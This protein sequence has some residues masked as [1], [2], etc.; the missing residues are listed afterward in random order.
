MPQSPASYLIHTPRYDRTPVTFILQH[1]FSDLISSWYNCTDCECHHTKFLAS[2]S[3]NFSI[4][5][6]G[7]NQTFSVARQQ[8]QWVTN[9][10]V[11][12]RHTSPT[13]GN[14][15]QSA[16]QLNTSSWSVGLPWSWASPTKLPGGS[17]QSAWQL[18]GPYSPVLQLAQ[19][20]SC[21]ALPLSSIKGARCALASIQL[22]NVNLTCRWGWT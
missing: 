18:L 13:G 15:S 10:P 8:T 12:H 11:R 3:M 6:F 9:Q 16:Q 21:N 5:Y 20:L 14:L 2:Q 1:V 17:S 22:H 7:E 4:I 19:I